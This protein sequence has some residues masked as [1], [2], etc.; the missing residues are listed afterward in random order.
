MR[1]NLKSDSIAVLQTY[2]ARASL[3]FLI[4]GIVIFWYTTCNQ[5]LIDQHSFRQCQTAMTAQ[6]FALGSPIQSFLYYETPELGAPWRVPFEFPLYQAVVAATSRT[7]GLPLT[8]VGRM[9]SGIFFLLSLWP[10]HSLAKSFNLGRRFFY[11]ISAFLLSSPL[12]LYW[13]RTFMIE[14]TAVF[15]GFAFLACIEKALSRDS[16]PWWICGLLSGIFCALV[17][18]TTF[19][20]FGVAAVGLALWKSS[21]RFS[22]QQLRCLAK[23]LAIVFFLGFAAILIAVLWT[24][25]A[26]S[27]KTQNPLTQTLTSKALGAWNY[28]TLQ[29][30]LNLDLWCNVLWL[31]VIPEIFGT[32]W[33]GGFFVATICFCRGRELVLVLSFCVLFL[34]PMILFTNLHVVHNYYQYANAFWLIFALATCTCALSRKLPP[35]AAM[36]VCV[37]IVASQILGFYQGGFYAAVE[38]FD[39]RFLEVAKKIRNATHEGTALL[40]FGDDWSPEVAFYSKRKA[41]YIR[42]CLGSVKAE[43]VYSQI[44]HNPAAVFGDCTLGAIVINNG[45]VS[46]NTYTGEMRH[47]LNGLLQRLVDK[48]SGVQVGTYEIH[49][50]THN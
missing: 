21:Y 23:H 13:S 38:L 12:Y 20:S 5:P 25:H 49:I 7:F 24:A 39:N 8:N 41:L 45:G 35:I 1:F 36:W 17:K 47:G 6:W 29:Q 27:I 46:A 26:D 14:S 10:I 48:S 32:V 37:L 34:L 43:E 4:C 40:V 30:K 11:I 9:V 28:G 18:I 33:I 2:I 44:I 22:R 15:F 19:P 50:I 42:G 16:W 3:G 31:R